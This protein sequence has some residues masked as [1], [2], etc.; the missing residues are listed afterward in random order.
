MIKIGIPSFLNSKIISYP[1]EHDA[2]RIPDAEV[3]RDVP[4]R[5]NEMLHGG[6]IELG[7]IS[8]GSLV[9]G[10]MI[11]PG[12]SISGPGKVESVVLLSNSE[13][14]D[15]D[16]KT[17]RLSDDSCTSN[18]LLELLCRGR[19]HIQPKFLRKD[20][21]SADAELMIGDK[22][23]KRQRDKDRPGFVID[24]AREWFDWTSLPMVFA[25]MVTKRKDDPIIQ[26][27][28]GIVSAKNWGVEHVS[29]VA[30]GSAPD[31]MSVEET[32]RYIKNIDY[33]LGHG[34]IRSIAMFHSLLKKHKLTDRTFKARRL[35]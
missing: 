6:R 33:S 12:I 16:G 19:Y 30:R 25:A 27:A 17:V 32:E 13:I 9:D 35:W 15:L 14:Q 5:L 20:V 24:L 2:V 7:L 3:I 23:L 18:L 1:I 8:T 10:D 22:A 31:F 11:V 34:H 26:A 21:N 4:S 29:E 28:R